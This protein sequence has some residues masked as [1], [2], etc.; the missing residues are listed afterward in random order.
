MESKL[1]KIK[2]IISVFNR[3]RS[4][5]TKRRIKLIEGFVQDFAKYTQK[6]LSAPEF[7]ALKSLKMNTDEI[8]HSTILA[9]ILDPK[10][11]EYEDNMFINTFLK[12]CHIN[13]SSDSLANY[14]IR[15]EFPGMESKIDLLLFNK[16]RFIIYVENKIYSREGINQCDRELR[17]LRRLGRQLCVPTDRQFA[18]YLTPNGRPPEQ[19]NQSNWRTLSYVQVGTNLR[20]LVSR[21]RSKKTLYLLDDWLEI[22]SSF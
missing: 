8:K 2:R 18:I 15:T 1:T 14:K 4:E 12:A 16:N 6:H 5:R 20:S 11:N 10:I 13:L 3:H 17:D 7:N 19:G 21:V 9:L 22:I